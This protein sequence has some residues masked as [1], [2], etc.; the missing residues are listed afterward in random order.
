MIR[1]TTILLCLILAAAAAGRYQAE[2]SVREI[3]NELQQLEN[4]KIEEAQSIQMLRAEVAYLESP[5]R[6][7]KIASAKT[8]LRPP[9]SSQILTADDFLAAFGGAPQDTPPNSSPVNSDVIL[10][11][12]ALADASSLE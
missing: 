2:E 7:S 1:V 3:R 6:L 11:A 9:E 10:H 8:D 12:L 4:S 5:E